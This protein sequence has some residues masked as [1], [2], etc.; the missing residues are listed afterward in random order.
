MH[1]VALTT[2]QLRHV[3][4]AVYEYWQSS[5]AMVRT[6]TIQL[7]SQLRGAR[8]AEFDSFVKELVRSFV[9]ERGCCLLIVFL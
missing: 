7:T 2:P 9:D 1:I 6:R 8:T 4:Q 5:R 3:A